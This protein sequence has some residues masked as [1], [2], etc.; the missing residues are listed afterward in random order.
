MST[1]SATQDEVRRKLLKPKVTEEEALSLLVDFYIADGFDLDASVPRAEVL[2]ELVSYDD[3]NFVVKVDGEKALLKIYNGV[4]S[5]K[6]IAKHARKWTKLDEADASN[7]D[8][9]CIIDLHTAIY[10]HLSAPKYNVTTGKTIPV[11]NSTSDCDTENDSVC[12]R[13]LSVISAGHGPQQLVVR[14]QSWV[15]GT[16]LCDVKWFP[17]ET[18]LDAGACLGRMCS[19]FDD[20]ATSD[21]DIL[22]ES[23]R[24]F[25]WDGR[26][27]LDAR[28][29]IVHID[30]IDKRKLVTSVLDEF[31]KTIVE[32][33]EGEK[34]R[35]GIIHGDFN[36][37]N[38]II[39][40]D[41]MI[42]GVIDFGD[43]LYR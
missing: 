14:L 6:Y 9:G 17:I 10:E 4:E 21:P 39:G 5:E 29:F 12:I 13:E 42:S 31:Q 27:L 38:L 32:G 19:A 3:A 35:M 26:N 34:L 20:L 36:D 22:Q 40:N 25:A 43:S 23:K 41:M 1:D 37:G 33:K 15:H 2:Q 16:P 24:Y 30:D 7:K 28:P 11:K 8:D 18:L